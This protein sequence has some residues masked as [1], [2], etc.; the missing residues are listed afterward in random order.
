MKQS[1]HAVLIIY[2]QYFAL[3]KATRTHL[4]RFTGASQILLS[5]HVAPAVTA[6]Q[7]ARFLNFSDVC[8]LGRKQ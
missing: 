1:K 5:V 4:E 6:D 7:Y 2:A 3:K 8:G